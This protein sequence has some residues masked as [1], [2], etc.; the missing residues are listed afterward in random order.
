MVAVAE[1]QVSEFVDVSVCGECGAVVTGVC[2]IEHPEAL[3]FDADAPQV[4]EILPGVP[5]VRDTDPLDVE[6]EKRLI[7]ARCSLDAF[8]CW[9]RDHGLPSIADVVE[10]QKDELMEIHR[11]VAPTSALIIAEAEGYARLSLNQGKLS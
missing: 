5:G 8:A 6:L 10:R 11:T 1:L 4:P 2:C 9:A 7:Y 3:L